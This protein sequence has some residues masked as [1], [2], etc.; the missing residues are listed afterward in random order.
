MQQLDKLAIERGHRHEGLGLR[1]ADEA[2]HDDF[3]LRLRE[4]ID[5]EALL[6]GK[7]VWRVLTDK[8]LRK[9]RRLLVHGLLYLRVECLRGGLDDFE[10]AGFAYA[11]AVV[12][13]V[14]ARLRKQFFLHLAASFLAFVLLIDL[15]LSLCNFLQPLALQTGQVEERLRVTDLKCV[16]QL[17]AK[18]NMSVEGLVDDL[19]LLTLRHLDC[20]LVK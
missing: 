2:G 3:E 20:L 10:L 16:V 19:D 5:Q 9:H 14:V 11:V 15:A 1:H 12:F 18:G 7:I 4:L 6:E 17:A 8:L 13:H